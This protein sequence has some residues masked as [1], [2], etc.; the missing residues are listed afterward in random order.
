MR[1]LGGHGLEGERRRQQHRRDQKAEQD[2]CPGIRSVEIDHVPSTV[3]A[4]RI[5]FGA[6]ARR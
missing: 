1:A 6:F 2:Q 4:S 5:E 3:A